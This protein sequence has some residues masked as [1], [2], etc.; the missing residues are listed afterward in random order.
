MDLFS[1]PYAVKRREP[2]PSEADWFKNHP[3]GQKT[4]GMAAEDD[5]VILNPH[6]KL[7]PENQ[8]SVLT[9]EAFRVLMRKHQFLRPSFGLTKEQ[10][11]AF[12]DYGPEEDQKSTV[13]ARL[14]SGDPSAGKPSPEQADYM[15]LIRWYFE[16]KEFGVGQ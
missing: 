4:A 5:A 14:I 3:K 1:G 6:M 10:Q 12:K 2:Y 8:Q 9:N 13:A 11:A 15:N 7:S 16:P